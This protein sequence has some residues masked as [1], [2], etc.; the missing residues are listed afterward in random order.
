MRYNA[1]DRF[2]G[3]FNDSTQDSDEEKTL[4]EAVKRLDNMLGEGEIG[5]I[6][7]AQYLDHDTYEYE[8]SNWRYYKK[9]NGK[10]IKIKEAEWEHIK[11]N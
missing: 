6:A 7:T 8:V 4:R 2:Y 3:V 5:S 9:E 11:S 1:I 10:L